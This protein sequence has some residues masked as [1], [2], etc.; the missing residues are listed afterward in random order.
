MTK[1]IL[2]VA[3]VLLMLF[4]MVAVPAFA[5]ENGN[6]KEQLDSELETVETTETTVT[7]DYAEYLTEHEG[8]AQPE[9][10][11]EVDVLDYQETSGC[12]TVEEESGEA[13]LSSASSFVEYSFEVPQEGLYDI[14]IYYRATENG[15]ANPER[16]IYIN[17]EIPYQELS[18]VDFAREWVNKDSEIQQDVNGNDIRPF[19]V[20][21][22]QWQTTRLRDAEGFYAQ[23]LQVYLKQGENTLALE[24]LREELVLGSITFAPAEAVPSY[25]EALAA[26]EEAG[27]Q[28]V[29]EA[30]MQIEGESAAYT[31]DPTLAPVNDRASP[32]VSPY[33]GSKIVMN[34]IGGSSWTSPGQ[35]IYWKIQVEESGLYQLAIKAKQNASPGK[36]SY[37][38]LSIDGKV[39]F[40]EAQEI[41]FQYTTNWENTLLADESGEAYWFYLEE[42]EHLLA[43][44]PSLGGMADIVREL[45]DSVAALNEVYRDI[46]VVTGTNPDQYRDY[47]LHIY[48]PD[49]MVT[50]EEQAAI[51]HDLADR[52]TE[53]TGSRSSESALMEN[54]ALQLDSFLEKPRTIAKRLTTYKS[55]L[56]GLGTLI[57]TLS[58]S[59]LVIDYLMLGGDLANNMPAAEANFFSK[60]VHSVKVFA[61]SFTEDYDS[62]GATELSGDAVQTIDVWIPTGRDQSQVIKRLAEESF[63]AE[64]GI[65]V[66]VKLVQTANI[67]PSV[68]SGNN[69]DVAIQLGM[70][71][72]VNYAMRG[73]LADLSQFESFSTVTERFQESAM[74]PYYLEDGV[75]G[76]PETQ[77][78][79]MQFYRKDIF[80]SL[81]L[82]VPETWDDFMQ[83][84]SVL[85]KNKLDVGL[86][87]SN[88]INSS[89]GTLN[90]GMQTYLMLLYQ[91]GEE[92]YR[93]GGAV[94]NLDSE[95]GIEMF[96]EWTNFYAN[97]NL[98]MTYDFANRFRLGEM[99]LAIVDYTS[100]N[101]LSVMAPEIKGLWGMAPVPGTVQEDG[102]IDRSVAFTGL[103]SVIFENSD[104]KEAAWQFLDWWTSAE[105]QTRYGLE[106]E[107]ILGASARYPT[108]N[109]EALSQLPWSAEEYS[110]IREQMD[111]VV[112]TPEVPGGYFTPRHIDNAFRATVLSD[113]DPRDALLDYIEFINEELATKRSE[114]GY[115]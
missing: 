14:E 48:L 84:L 17:G 33:N 113:K 11:V 56:S 52:L 1:R 71:D 92:L 62:A 61:A 8:L 82:E 59:P 81:G 10:P 95:I 55:N 23:P 87:Y 65:A 105:T 90:G 72:P 85:Q 38:K 68:I 73:A 115:N 25:D 51:L 9:D 111:W 15:T 112:G 110:Q 86:P 45:E 34:A 20:T 28:P 108:A 40:V 77:S 75:Y 106:M 16:A 66:N 24:A 70:A 67:L 88:V 63:T 74:V 49:I 102:T 12:E 3:L 64:T 19:Q 109:I 96:E 27:A 98:P 54:T 47:D 93:D 114:F 42:G 44:E 30:Y 58:E 103:A 31:S 39:P 5:D 91:N 26:W 99:P 60:I 101:M 29:S 18:S 104:K 89:Y 41:P 46:I 2:T 94:S 6:E 32:S 7:K 80:E 36:I 97:W 13:L 78:F 76:L 107:N 37:R 4:G 83:V 100:Y 22:P 69:P 50:F 43:L 53:I 57:L 21:D 35:T 79:L